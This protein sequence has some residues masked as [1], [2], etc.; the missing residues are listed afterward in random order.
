[1]EVRILGIPFANDSVEALVE[2][3]LKGGLVVV[4]SGPGLA[5]DLRNNPDYRKAVTSADLAIADSGAMV[6]FWKL[7]R[8]KSIE[9]VSGLRF[10]KHL[11]QVESLKQP[12]AT[13]WV[14]PTEGQMKVN[15][16]WLKEQGF[17]L[18]DSC[19][20]IAPMYPRKDIQDDKLW[21]SLR[22]ENPKAIILCIGG[23]VQERLGWWIREQYRMASRR[24]PAVICTGAAI[25]FLSGNQINVPDWADRLYLTWLV[26]CVSNPKTYIP[27]YWSALPIAWRII[28]YGKKLPM[29]R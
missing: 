15:N 11:L 28:R 21:E 29:P 17:F 8:G 4:P 5:V 7:F 10:L 9:R 6:L 2:R 13:F 27:R 24:C 26:R 18:K 20:Y 12:G 1:M 3:S 25:G 23:G 19:N 14:H 16:F 22:A